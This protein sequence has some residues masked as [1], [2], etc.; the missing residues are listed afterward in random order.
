MIVVVGRVRTDAGKREQ[1]IEVAQTVA[2]ASREETGCIGY[3]V[4][5]DTERPNDFVFVEEWADDAALQ[6]HFGTSHIA[7]FMAAVR[8]AIIAPPEVDFHQI[9]GTRTLADVTAG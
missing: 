4:C 2:R 3:R 9:A 7:A 6:A 1:L 5:E 8:A